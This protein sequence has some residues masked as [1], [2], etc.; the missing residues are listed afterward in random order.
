[1]DE[2]TGIYHLGIPG[3]TSTSDECGKK[4]KKCGIFSSHYTC[5]P[6]KYSKTDE[7]LLKTGVV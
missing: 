2:I 5:I 7:T 6:C 4:K 3:I 1:M